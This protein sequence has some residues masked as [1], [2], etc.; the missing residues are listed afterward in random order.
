MEM[1][2]VYD[3]DRS[4]KVKFRKI[5]AKLEQILHQEGNRHFLTLHL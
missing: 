1:Y 2:L 4:R 5:F 3:V